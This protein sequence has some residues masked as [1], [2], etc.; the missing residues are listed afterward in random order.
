M[1]TIVT[2]VPPRRS[3]RVTNP[4]QRL[5]GETPEGENPKTPAATGITLPAVTHILQ[6]IAAESDL[7]V[8]SKAPV[9]HPKLPL[10]E[11]ISYS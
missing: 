9:H 1:V 5:R 8:K 10:E 6:D 11:D 3:T 4:P 2:P 7:T